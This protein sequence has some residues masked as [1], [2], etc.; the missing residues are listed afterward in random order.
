[1]M[2]AAQMPRYP[3]MSYHT[4]QSNSPASVAS[5]SAHEQRSIYGQ[6]PSH[7]QHQSIYYGQQQ[8]PQYSSMPPQ[9]P[10][11]YQQHAQQPH[12][13]MTSQPSMMMSQNGPQHQI[14]QHASQHAQTG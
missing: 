4:P 8:Q 3:P 12:Q 11:P 6:P 5:P 9:A 2:A 14:P 10:S 1:M 7:L 13:S